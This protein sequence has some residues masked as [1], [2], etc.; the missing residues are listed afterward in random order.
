MPLGDIALAQNRANLR[1]LFPIRDCLRGKSAL[2]K[3][4]ATFAKLTRPRLHAAVKRVRLFKLL[5]Q[6]K[7]FPIFGSMGR[8]ALAKRPWLQVIW[9]LVT[10]KRSGIKSMKAIAIQ[11]HSFTG[12]P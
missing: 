2:P 6:R 3:T 9:K 4:R 11:Q 7:R 1:I 10:R 5:D 12:M 8:Q